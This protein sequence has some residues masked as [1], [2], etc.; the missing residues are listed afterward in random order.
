MKSIIIFNASIIV[1][2]LENSYLLVLYTKKEPEA[3]HL[4]T[5]KTLDLVA[6][7]KEV[8]PNDVNQ[9]NDKF[10]ILLQFSYFFALLHRTERLFH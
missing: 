6:I 7:R 1:L 8:E 9:P 4:L 5:T 3:L 10:I 2:M